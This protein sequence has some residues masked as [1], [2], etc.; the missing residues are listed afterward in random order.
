MDDHCHRLVLVGAGREFR[1][2]LD[3]VWADDSLEAVS[4]A[5]LEELASMQ[6]LRRP[7][8]FVVL[9]QSRPGQF[10]HG[11]LEAL[12][13]ALPDTNWLCV[14]GSFA[15]GE[16]R[17]GQPLPGIDRV[18]WSA[19][20]DRFTRLRELWEVEPASDSD[21]FERAKP[22]DRLLALNQGDRPY[23]YGLGVVAA[24]ATVAEPLI[25]ACEAAGFCAEWLPVEGLQATARGRF[26]HLNLCIWIQEV[27]QARG[28]APL[29]QV[30]ARVAP[31]P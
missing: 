14:V 9:L 17:S 27:S 18:Y 22:A 19:A 11:E 23:P 26:D 29:D 3:H 7:P 13:R 1:G 20:I 5:T 24:T 28:P 25:G 2:L 4:L 31:C 30:V 16:T 6:Q 15:E 12:Q 8:R 21:S 10:L